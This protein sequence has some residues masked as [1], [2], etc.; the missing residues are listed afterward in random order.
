MLYYI[1][2][3]QRCGS[4]LM[5]NILRNYLEINGKD[6][7]VGFSHKA[8]IAIRRCKYSTVVLCLR[9][10]INEWVGSMLIAQSVKIWCYYDRTEIKIKHML[11]I[12]K[13]RIDKMLNYYYRFHKVAIKFDNNIFWYEDWIDDISIVGKR[14][15]IE[16]NVDEMTDMIKLRKTPINYTQYYDQEEISKYISEFQL[17]NNI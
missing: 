11:P 14:L 8:K 10:N 2:S 17:H 5:L 7:E 1:G 15:N 4:V 16:F 3:Q 13:K 6:I 9:R 12:N